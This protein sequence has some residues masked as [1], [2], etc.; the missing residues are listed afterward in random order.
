[1]NAHHTRARRALAFNDAL[2]ESPTMQK[3]GALINQSQ[4]Q[5][6]SIAHLL[7]KSSGR[8]IQ[9]GPIDE[10]GWCLLV[11]NAAI[12]SKLRQLIPDIERHL[13]SLGAQPAKVRIKILKH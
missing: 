1:M 10:N 8:G 5:L 9:A 11:S 12:A 4:S 13:L 2:G 7:P 6:Q 3:L